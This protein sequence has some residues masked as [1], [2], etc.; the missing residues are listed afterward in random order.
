[1][2]PGSASF[3]DLRRSHLTLTVACLRLRNER[4]PGD[5]VAQGEASQRLKSH[6]VTTGQFEDSSRLELTIWT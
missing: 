3:T 4:A 6:D 5:Y 2:R 1:M